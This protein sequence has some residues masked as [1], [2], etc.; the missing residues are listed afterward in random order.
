MN[1]EVREQRARRRRIEEAR[2]ER[3]L[4][5]VRAWRRAE[6]IRAYVAA[7]ETKLPALDGEERTRV[8]D[9]CAWAKA[10]ADGSDPGERPSLIIGIDDEADG[11]RSPFG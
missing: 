6:E 5:E 11:P 9:W 8:A 2:V 10:W 7:V 1:S 4:A 3:L